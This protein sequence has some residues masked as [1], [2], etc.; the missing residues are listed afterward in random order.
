MPAEIE[1]SVLGTLTWNE[2]LGSWESEIDLRADCPIDFRLV[3]LMDAD[4]TNEFEGAVQGCIDAIECRTRVLSEIRQGGGASTRATLVVIQQQ[5]CDRMQSRSRQERCFSGK[6]H[7][8][9]LSGR[10]TSITRG[11]DHAVFQDAPR[12][13][14]SARSRMSQASEGISPA[15]LKRSCK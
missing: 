6:S 9:L 12:L 10:I 13:S 7:F 11:R 8:F 5:F 2:D 14:C 15:S 4:P 3:T 1:H